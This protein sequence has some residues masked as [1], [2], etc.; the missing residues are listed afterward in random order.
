[1]KFL[2]KDLE[3]IIFETDNEILRQ[4]GL[5]ENLGKKK[6]Q[7]RIG[8][9]GISDIISYFRPREYKCTWPIITIL[10][11]KKDI[12]DVN[13]VLQGARYMKG[14]EQ[15]LRKTNRDTSIEVRLCLIGKNKSSDIIYFPDLFDNIGIYTYSYGIDGLYFEK[16]QNYHLLDEG[17]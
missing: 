7:V 15:Y 4:R 3:D 2:E 12:I 16:C 14:V 11:L 17:F 13:T 6:R 8:N 1:M 10:E 5:A 9:Y